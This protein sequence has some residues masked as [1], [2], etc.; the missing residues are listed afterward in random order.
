MP[1]P[2]P[3]AAARRQRSKRDMGADIGLVKF[4]GD[5]SE[6]ADETVRARESRVERLLGRCPV[7]RYARVR[8]AA[9]LEMGSQFGQVPPPRRRGRPWA[10]AM[11]AFPAAFASAVAAL[12]R[13]WS[14][15]WP[16]AYRRP[17]GPLTA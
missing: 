9:R 11:A 2:P 6:D 16:A 7:G 8:R 14:P 13:L 4:V 10:S 17:G 12:R 5:G 15:V 3:K 1:G